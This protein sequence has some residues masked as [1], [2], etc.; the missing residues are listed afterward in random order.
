MW[1]SGFNMLVPI[2]VHIIYEGTTTFATWLLA[3]RELNQ[4]IREELQILEEASAGAPGSSA[5]ATATAALSDEERDEAAIRALFTL[6]DVDKS[7]VIDA[8]EWSL[9][10]RLLGYV[11]APPLLLCTPCCHA[12]MRDKESAPT[13]KLYLLL[14]LLSASFMNIVLVGSACL[15]GPRRLAP[16]TRSSIC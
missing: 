15:L 11:L 8:D 4:R 6:L 14:F 9:G 13:H 5:T 10:L 16:T 2:F 3:S 1:L 7:G 12:A